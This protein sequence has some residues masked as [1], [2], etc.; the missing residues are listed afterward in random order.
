MTPEQ[1]AAFIISQSVCAI[2]EMAGMQ[3]ANQQRLL[4]NE[5]VRY[6]E[7]DFLSIIE[8]NVVGHNAVIGFFRQ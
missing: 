1:Q 7:Q 6:T 8:T 2:I 4:N 3:A 5:S